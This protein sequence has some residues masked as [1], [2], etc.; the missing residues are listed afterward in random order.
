MHGVTEDPQTQSR[1]WLARQLSRQLPDDASSSGAAGSASP[2]EAQAHPLPTRRDSEYGSQRSHRDEV[3]QASPR[4][5]GVDEDS[6]QEME[7]AIN[8]VARGNSALEK[9]LHAR[10]SGSSFGHSLE[11]F[12]TPPATSA[13]PPA[14]MSAAMASMS[15]SS[16]RALHLLPS[17]DGGEGG[18]GGAGSSVSYDMGSGA[19]EIAA[20][21]RAALGELGPRATL[22]ELRLR[23]ESRLRR[24]LDEWREVLKQVAAEYAAQ[25]EDDAP[26]PA[27]SYPRGDSNRT[28]VAQAAAKGAGGSRELTAFTSSNTS[29]SALDN[30]PTPPTTIQEARRGDG[31]E[32]RPQ[33]PTKKASQTPQ[34]GPITPVAPAGSGK[35][36]TKGQR[37]TPKP[38]RNLSGGSFF[39]LAQKSGASKKHGDRVDRVEGGDD[40]LQSRVNDALSSKK[41][42]WWVI[43][44]RVNK[45][46]AYWDGV[47]VAMLCFTALITP[48]EVGF[49][50]P[51]P[52]SERWSNPLF[53]TNRIVDLTFLLDIGLQFCLAYAAG[54][55]SDSVGKYWELDPKDIAW[56]YVTSFWFYLDIVS[57]GV[58][59]F[60]IFGDDDSAS[61]SGFRAV[62]V[63]RLI[64]LLRLTR[65]SRVFKRWELRLSINCAPP[66]I[67]HAPN[68]D[69]RLRIHAA[70]AVA[71]ASCPVS[72]AVSRALSLA[73]TLA[74]SSS[75]SL[76]VSCATLPCAFS[77]PGLETS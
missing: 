1:V 48:F 34:T 75:V 17:P 5:E 36:T 28:A 47:T 39:D 69:P 68:A 14:P 27:R 62:R 60:D 65:S 20:A 49:L 63:L 53:L 70:A 22:K 10:M 71:R 44:P 32:A 55:G 3:K 42:H 77:S 40:T 45:R 26:P 15:A 67:C 30:G 6:R 37:Q 12:S 46:I 18:E 8:Q 41:R 4:A 61:L 9:H 35:K 50:E 58:S 29:A 59:G 25:V 21:A 38:K 72:C 43:D 7:H 23:L 11:E 2:T 74:V 31:S 24:P 66:V 73:V 33:T 16:R 56:H 51:L 54:G 52:V 64:K 19:A 13:T 57:V 76:A